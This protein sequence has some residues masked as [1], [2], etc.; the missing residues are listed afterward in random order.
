[1]QSI[2]CSNGDDDNDNELIKRGHQKWQLAMKKQ[3]AMQEKATI[4]RIVATDRSIQWVIVNGILPTLKNQRGGY[5][6]LFVPLIQTN[7]LT[8]N[9]KYC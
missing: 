1:M 6:H 7:E 4:N 2:N 9:C 3:S 8:T 5:C